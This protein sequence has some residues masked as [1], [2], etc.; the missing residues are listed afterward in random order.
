MARRAMM[1]DIP[2]LLQRANQLMA[3]GNYPAAAE[4]F[5]QLG[6]GAAARGGPRAPH[7]FLQAGRARLLAGQVPAGMA[8][9]EQGLVMFATQNRLPELQR[10]GLRVVSELKGRGLTVEVAQIEELLARSFPGGIPAAVPGAAPAQ[11]PVLPTNCAGCGGPLR[12]DEVEWIDAV[13]AE[14]P[15]CGSAVRAE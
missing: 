9:L 11:K 13:T 15:F 7:F 8:L 10:A 1:P 14:C 6:R 12:S 4:A 2:P 5:E 3:A